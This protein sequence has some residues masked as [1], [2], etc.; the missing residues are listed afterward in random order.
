MAKP[1]TEEQY[2][3]VIEYAIKQTVG[4]EKMSYQNYLDSIPKKG[5]VKKDV[6]E[7][8]G[9]WKEWWKLWPS[10]RTFEYQ[11]QKFICE[12]PMKKNMEKM[13]E[14]WLAIVTK[15]IT[16]GLL[17]KAAHKFLTSTMI[18]SVRK[19]RNEMEFVNGMEPW[20][21]QKQWRN[22]LETDIIEETQRMQKVQSADVNI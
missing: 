19:G 18:N 22:W 5:K 13:K 9:E 21:N 14:K 7:L 17:Y 12:K 15:E 16:P 2:N 4:D 20:L 10:M 8:E 6:G 3:S 1:A 11:G